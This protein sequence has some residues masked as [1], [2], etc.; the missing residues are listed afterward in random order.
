MHEDIQRLLHHLATTSKQVI[1]GHECIQLP[2]TVSQLKNQPFSFPTIYI[3]PW[4]K[5][6][7]EFIFS[8]KFDKINGLIIVGQPGIGKS[9]F[10]W[11]LLWELINRNEKVIFLHFMFFE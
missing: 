10:S 11:L 1:N 9:V 3:T 8:N 5:E 6:M 2:A 7:Q 4:Y